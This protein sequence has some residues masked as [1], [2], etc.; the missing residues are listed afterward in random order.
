MTDFFHSPAQCDGGHR[1]PRNAADTPPLL[2]AVTV[3]CAA[4]FILLL[5]LWSLTPVT[6]VT[7]AVVYEKRKNHQ[8]GD[9]KSDGG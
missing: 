8:E 9:D 2:S 1:H 7:A 4:I 5:F 6:T 3:T